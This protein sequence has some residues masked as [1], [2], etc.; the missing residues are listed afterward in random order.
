MMSKTI[1]ILGGGV[2]GLVTANALSDKLGG[3]HRIVVV[4]KQ[5]DHLFT[6]SLL[7]LMVG[8]RTPDQLTKDLRLLL[9]PGIE[10][11]NAEVQTIDPNQN[12]VVVGGKELAYDYMVVALGADL[13]PEAMP[14][15]VEAA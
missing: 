10:V 12:R 2:G 9:R 14:G 8:W 7:W 15:Y 13:T 1:L 6:P 5:S 4:D 11:L 3:D